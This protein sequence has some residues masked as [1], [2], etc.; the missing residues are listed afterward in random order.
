M[1]S[2]QKQEID[3]VKYSVEDYRKNS[4]HL[5]VMYPSPLKGVFSPS[6]ILGDIVEEGD[7]LGE[8]QDLKEGTILKIQAEESGVVF[9]VRTVPSVRNGEALAGILPIT[10]TGK[11]SIR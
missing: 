10:Q 1:V 8:V 6:V 5:Q 9:L 11:V 3:R 7:M 2:E 4:G